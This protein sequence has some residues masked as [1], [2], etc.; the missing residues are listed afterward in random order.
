MSSRDSS[1]AAAKRK[2]LCTVISTTMFLYS[3]SIYR[4]AEFADGYGGSI[5]SA[6]W[7]F[8]VF[9]TILIFI[10]FITYV[11]M[12]LGPHFVRGRALVLYS[13]EAR[14]AS[15]SMSQ[16]HTF[17]SRP[18][19]KE[20]AKK[21]EKALITFSLTLTKLEIT[22]ALNC[23]LIFYS[24]TITTCFAFLYI[25]SHIEQ[26]KSTA[27]FD[28]FVTVDWIDD[29]AKEKQQLQGLWSHLGTRRRASPLSRLYLAYD[30]AV[31]WIVVLLV[32]IVTEWLSDTKLRRVGG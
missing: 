22:T 7:A 13:D 15:M 17:L 27:R 30:A 10:A 21:R 29:A 4:I 12:P 28:E 1:S 24:Y 20:G 26:A 6:E 19:T 32:S 5:Y 18:R 2:V 11:A 31:S 3:R 9:D 25:M 8:Y 23:L 14:S 16:L